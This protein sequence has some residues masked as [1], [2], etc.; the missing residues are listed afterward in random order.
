[1]AQ[2]EERKPLAILR[3][4]CLSLDGDPSLCEAAGA[5]SWVAASSSSSSA[6]SS[7]SG[8]EGRCLIH[9][10]TRDEGTNVVRIFTARLSDELLRYSTARREIL[11]NHVQSIRVP[12]GAVRV[13]DELFLATKPKEGA[14]SI[15]SRLG[16][17]GQTAISFPEEMLRFE[18]AEEELGAEAEEVTQET[19]VGSP[20]PASWIEKG[21]AIPSPPAGLEGANRLAFA[22]GTGRPIETWETYIKNRRGKLGLA[23]DPSRPFQWSRQDF[24]VVASLTL[25]N[26][27]FVHAAP[28]GAIVI[29]RWIAPPGAAAKVDQQMYM[30]LW[31]PRQ[32]LVTKGLPSRIYR[33]YTKDLPTDLVMALDGASPLS[34]EE[35]RGVVEDEIVASASASAP[36]LVVAS[37]SEVTAPENEETAPTIVNLATDESKET[38]AQSV[39][40]VASEAVSVANEAAK[41]ATEAAKAAGSAVLE[42]SDQAAAAAQT[43]VESI[44]PKEEVNEAEGEEAEVKEEAKEE[45]KEAEETKEEVKE[46]EKTA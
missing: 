23:G 18:G 6:S 37:S 40:N 33:F 27:L 4:D 30:I 14:A 15:L 9:A 32:L 28:S 21:L 5:C 43:F 12:R 3:Q 44:L 7:G 25:S 31:G 46:E 2:T 11:D 16:F 10:P 41:A 36:V 20:L 17:T 8:S 35:A 19:G 38:P 26:V 1:V 45:L 13:G 24:Y 29:D 42:A 22:E 34:D 39:V